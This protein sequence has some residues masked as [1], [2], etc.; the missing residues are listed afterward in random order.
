[1]VFSYKNVLLISILG[2]VGSMCCMDQ[3]ESG[4]ESRKFVS[5]ATLVHGR[6]LPLKLSRVPVTIL[7]PAVVR[8][9]EVMPVLP[10]P[11][12]KKMRPAPIIPIVDQMPKDAV[13]ESVLSR[14]VELFSHTTSVNCVYRGGNTLL[15]LA[16]CNESAEQAC[17]L[18]EAIVGNEHLT[19]INFQNNDGKT[20]LH[21]VIERFSDRMP[22]QESDYCYKMIDLLKSHGAHFNFYGLEAWVAAKQS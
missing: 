16:C 4:D 1:M 12:V 7:K 14:L 15:H 17:A 13:C 11:P 2:L 3:D 20:A 22:R 9:G 21:L 19:A 18:V 10:P 8:V 5:L 6:L